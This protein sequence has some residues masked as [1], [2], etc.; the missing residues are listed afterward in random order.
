MKSQIRFV[1]HPN[2][3]A[4]FF[5]KCLASSDIFLIDGPRWQAPNPKVHQSLADINGNYCIVWSNQDADRLQSRYVHECGDWY[6]DSEFLTI[7]FLRSQLIDQ[8]LTEGHLAVS[9]SGANEA[10]TKALSQR[11]KLY[12]SYLKREYSNAIIEWFNPNLPESSLG[13][14]VSAN[15]TKPDLQVWVG[16]HARNWMLQDARHRIKQFR[17]SVVEA[18]LVIQS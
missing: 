10:Q 6:C 7:Q 9:T 4:D 17:S 18:R 16:P 8:V 5:S 2:D 3:E 1:M 11:F 15:P 14:N 13:L 12:S